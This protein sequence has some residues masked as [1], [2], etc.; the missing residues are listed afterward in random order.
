LKI[1]ILILAAGSSSR[2]GTPKQLLPYKE[3]T[4]LGT[5]VENALGSNTNDV[6]V[7]L[8]SNA[9]T[10]QKNINK[11]VEI[12]INNT[13]EK[14]LSSSIVKG[15]ISL[16]DYDAVLIA[17]GDQ[18]HISFDYY[19]QM[20]S[21][22]KKHPNHSITSQYKNHK[23]VPALFPKQYFLDLLKLNGDY[24]AKALL[25]SDTIL[26]KTIDYSVNLFDIDTPEDYE[27][28]INNTK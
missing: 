20:I 26:T 8:G 16:L 17:L 2:M 13:F 10:I 25:N 3:S 15:I 24:G 28:L 27:K 4:I 23:G 1:A 5:V 14:G 18:P 12:I 6:F 11:S 9:D 19:N 7:L 21:E 22:L